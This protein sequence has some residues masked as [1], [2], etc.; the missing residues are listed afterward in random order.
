M[1][2]F[3]LGVLVGSSAGEVAYMSFEGEILA[4]KKISSDC[5]SSILECENY[6]VTTGYDG[7][8]NFLNKG[9]LET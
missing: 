9:N 4:R 7:L 2:L 1:T 6:I 5:I 3:G 8:V